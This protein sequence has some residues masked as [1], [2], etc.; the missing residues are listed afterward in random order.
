M[1]P[2]S[3]VAGAPPQAPAAPQHAEALSRAHAFLDAT[4]SVDAGEA[5][6]APSAARSSPPTQP[7][8]PSPSPSPSP[9][10]FDVEFAAE[11]S[12]KLGFELGLENNE[13]GSVSQG[14][15]AEVG[16]LRRGDVL[17]AVAGLSI[18]GLSGEETVAL[19]LA[20]VRP[21]R[22]T[23]ARRDERGE[24]E[25]GAAATTV[26]VGAGA[27]PAQPRSPAKP[28]PPAAATAG[29][30][31]AL[32]AGAASDDEECSR[33]FFAGVPLCARNAALAQLQARLDAV[34]IAAAAMVGIAAVCA[35]SGPVSLLSSLAVLAQ[36]L[37]WMR[38]SES[39]LALLS[40]Y[41]RITPASGLDN[42][43]GELQLR[44]V[45]G[46]FL[47]TLEFIIIQTSVWL[48]T[49]RQ[50]F[51]VEQS[52]SCVL[53]H[54][55]RYCS[56]PS[57]AAAIVKIEGA[58]EP[59]LF[60]AAGQSLPTTAVNIG[61]SVVTLQLVTQLHSAILNL[62]RSAVGA[63]VRRVGTGGH[64]QAL[65]SV[66][67]GDSSDGSVGSGVR[68]WIGDAPRLTSRQRIEELE[69]AV[70]AL[71]AISADANYSLFACCCRRPSA[72]WRC[73]IA[74]CVVAASASVLGGVLSALYPY[75]NL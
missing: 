25:A 68:E 43:L 7:P 44:A 60:F 28:A 46:V 8:S 18:A 64:V 45:I 32:Q 61:F 52:N 69:R 34:R 51:A 27:A 4:L 37:L 11:G 6:A 26:A 59:W 35:V 57:L 10:V 62:R 1:D 73:G 16:G 49:G 54:R 36:G 72:S 48:T 12:T 75:A 41:T 33:A 3:G 29:A 24:T 70:D 65:A 58:L 55:Q 66:V 50:I 14:S 30:A 67:H 53:Y 5:F 15:A 47:A 40:A 2:T 42:A 63:Q 17:I 31:T 20:K 74:L 9:F 22:L 13:V 56:A 71:A 39:P 19:L 38:I 21:M 23:F